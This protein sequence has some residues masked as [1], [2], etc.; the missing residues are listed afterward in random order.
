MAAGNFDVA[1]RYVLGHE[2]GYINHPDDPGGPTNF[3]VTQRVYDSW[4]LREGQAKQ[5]VRKITAD[6]VAAIY[7]RQYWDAVCGD[8]LPSGVDYAVFDFA[9]NSGQARSAR[10]LQKCIGANRDGIVGAETVSK[11]SEM[12]EADLIA[13]LCEARLK[14]V[15]G[16]KKYKTFGRGWERRIRGDIEGVQADDVGVLDR[17]T[18]MAMAEP[19][20]YEAPA[21]A[22]PGKAEGDKA[23]TSAVGDMLKDPKVIATGLGA[24]TTTAAT[25]AKMPWENLL[26]LGVVA[27]VFGVVALQEWKR[28]RVAE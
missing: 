13:S 11:A 16:L 24:A 5:S 18:G 7:R 3:G 8:D 26:I 14:Y 10:Y 19:V 15:R 2:G 1:L 28:A 12:D 20:I 25:V 9:V 27:C 23:A 17:A 4:R 22:C 21:S 6:E